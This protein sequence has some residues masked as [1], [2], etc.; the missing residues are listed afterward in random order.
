MLVVKR[1]YR[2][3]FGSEERLK[4]VIDKVGKRYQ[5]ENWALKLIWLVTPTHKLANH[6]PI[7]DSNSYQIRTR[8]GGAR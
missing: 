8:S 6:C 3:A 7:K 5:G 1:Y 4:L 2:Y